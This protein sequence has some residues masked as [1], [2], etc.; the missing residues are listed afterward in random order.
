ML[1]VIGGSSIQDLEEGLE[2]LKR[3]LGETTCECEYDDY[4]EDDYNEDDDQECETCD[5]YCPNCDE[6]YQETDMEYCP[7]CGEQL[8]ES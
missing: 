4:D 1:M 3:Q 7:Y 5:K 6:E 2:A 8:E